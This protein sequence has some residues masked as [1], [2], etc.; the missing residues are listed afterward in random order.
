[1]LKIF[2]YHQ[3]LIT[4][5][6]WKNIL[7]ILTAWEELLFVGCRNSHGVCLGSHKEYLE[8]SKEMAMMLQDKFFHKLKKVSLALPKASTFP[9]LRLEFFID[10]KSGE[11]V[12]NEIETLADCRSYSTYLLEHKGKFYL[13]GWRNK[14]YHAFTSPLTTTLLRDCLKHELEK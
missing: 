10:N 9:N 2:T 11:W 12:L 3:Y 6:K 4:T 1:M 14:T 13:N 5:V 7:E 8:S